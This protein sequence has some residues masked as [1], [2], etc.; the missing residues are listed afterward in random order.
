MKWR[1]QTARGM[2]YEDD[3]YKQDRNKETRF[4]DECKRVE[5]LVLDPLS[6]EL[7]GIVYD[8][9]QKKRAILSFEFVYAIFP[10]VKALF[11]TST[12]F[13]LRICIHF[14]EFI[15]VRSGNKEVTHLKKVY[16]SKSQ[17]LRPR[18]FKQ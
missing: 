14:V 18:Q 2:M 9:K 11:V 8:Q 17:P 15:R 13:N 12:T 7:R 4:I 1:L 6:P 3:D 16:F 5:S 10:N